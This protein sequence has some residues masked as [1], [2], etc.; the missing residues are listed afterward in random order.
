[1][2]LQVSDI[3]SFAPLQC[4]KGGVLDSDCR[5]NFV[6]TQ[7][8]FSNIKTQQAGKPSNV[9]FNQQDLALKA[10]QKTAEITRAAM[11]YLA[12]SRCR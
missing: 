11:S 7:F 2:T 9:E 5:V 6:D 12:F 3:S 10:L 8:V 1:M 4:I